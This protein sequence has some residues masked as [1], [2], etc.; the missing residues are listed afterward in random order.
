[1]S[2]GSLVRCQGLPVA[3]VGRLHLLKSVA[4][5]ECASKDPYG[6]GSWDH[7][8]WYGSLARSESLR[9]CEGSWVRERGSESL[10]N[11]A[12]R[13]SFGAIRILYSLRSTALAC[14]PLGPISHGD[15][16]F[17]GSRDISGPCPERRSPTLGS[18]AVRREDSR[19]D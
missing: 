11:P 10:A 12:H 7:R 18:E 15:R 2:I 16:G 19:P 8:P 14:A 13:Q 3:E 4:M 5:A 1:M 17:S 6:H 9:T